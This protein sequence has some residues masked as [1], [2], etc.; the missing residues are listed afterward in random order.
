[1]GCGGAPGPPPP[2]TGTHWPGAGIS[3]DIELSLGSLFAGDER[4]VIVEMEGTASPGAQL[5]FGGNVSWNRV[6]GAHS[7]VG[8]GQLALVGT[9]DPSAVEAGRDGRVFAS[10]TSAT[11]STA[12]LEA[13]EAFQKGDVDKAQ[14]ILDQSIT[15]LQAAAATAPAPVASSLERQW[16]D[17]KARKAPM[18]KAGSAAGNVAAKRAAAVDNNNLVRSGF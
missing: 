1:V 7:D 6:G 9:T 10:A 11:A 15:D 13:A 12:Q 3:S 14:R 16:T 8:I 2:T 5:A 17:Y 18:S 4:R